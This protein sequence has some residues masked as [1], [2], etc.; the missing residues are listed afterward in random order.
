MK[1]SVIIPVYNVSGYIEACI[2]SI[3]SQTYR[4]MEIILVNDGSTDDSG[5]ILHRYAASDPRILVFDKHNGGLSD[6]RNYGLDRSSGELIAFV[7]GDDLLEPDT[8][9]ENVPFFEKDTSLDIL[10][11]PIIDYFGT[12]HAVKRTFEGKKLTGPS[13]IIPNWFRNTLV[14]YS[15]CNKLFRKSSIGNFR[16][17]KNVIF[18]DAFFCCDIAPV[19]QNLQ[20]SGKGG[21]C[22]RSRENSITSSSVSYTRYKFLLQAQRNWLDIARN[23]SSPRDVFDYCLRTVWTHILYTNRWTESERNEVLEQLDI[24]CRFDEKAKTFIRNS[25]VKQKILFHLLTHAGLRNTARWIS[26]VFL[27]TGK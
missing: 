27:L 19:I 11:Y 25:P 6:A 10:Q 7:D 2:D 18:E 24:F 13:E 23:L 22:Y 15:V 12:P 16:F 26:S 4:D 3:L 20:L 14:S 1:V 8:L 17:R 9:S 21:Y 5:K